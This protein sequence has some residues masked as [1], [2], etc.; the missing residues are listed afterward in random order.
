MT[1]L[2]CL[3][4]QILPWLGLGTTKTTSGR[5]PHVLRGSR[6]HRQRLFT[7]TSEVRTANSVLRFKMTLFDVTAHRLT[8]NELPFDTSLI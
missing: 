1:E 4:G 8:L 2:R 3:L 5:D 6:R 7:D